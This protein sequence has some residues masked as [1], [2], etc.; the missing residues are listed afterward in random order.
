MNQEST[1]TPR[2]IRTIGPVHLEPLGDG[3]Y[4]V[5]VL[6]RSGR[7]TPS[8]PEHDQAMERAHLLAIQT[9]KSVVAYALGQSRSQDEQP[10]LSPADRPLHSLSTE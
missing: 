10:D 9:I 6:S 4:L 3:S 5:H 2:A 1:F 8:T 7:K